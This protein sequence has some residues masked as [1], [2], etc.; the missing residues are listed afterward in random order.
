VGHRARHLICAAPA[1]R[2]AD[3]YVSPGVPGLRLRPRASAAPGGPAASPGW[4]AVQ[5]VPNT[6]P[7]DRVYA[8]LWSRRAQLEG[9]GTQV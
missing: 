3:G 4:Y 1:S 9:Q 5:A 7:F 2:L 8:A 6:G